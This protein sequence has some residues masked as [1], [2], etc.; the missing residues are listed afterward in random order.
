MLVKKELGVTECAVWTQ[1]HVISY[2]E[3]MGQVP[4]LS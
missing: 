3:S 1:K 4:G 2:S